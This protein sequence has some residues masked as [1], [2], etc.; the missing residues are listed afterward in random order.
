MYWF[1]SWCSRT[2]PIVIFFMRRLLCFA[3]RTVSYW[4]ETCSRMYFLAR[5]S[6]PL[7][8]VID[9]CRATA[10]SR[11]VVAHNKTTVPLPCRPG[12]GFAPL[13]RRPGVVRALPPRFADRWLHQT[14][15]RS[16]FHLSGFPGK[17]HLPFARAG[18]L[19]TH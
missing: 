6:R 17:A 5:C 3:G 11:S 9:T 10:T 16:A 18:S 12:E 15:Y 4:N 2:E 1:V 14:C 8:V 13:E 19:Y 7:T